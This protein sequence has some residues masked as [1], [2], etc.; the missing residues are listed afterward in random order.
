[1]KKKY[2]VELSEQEREYLHKLISSGTAPA[3]KF[4]RARIL[5]KADVDKHAEAQALNDRQIARMLETPLPQSKGHANA[6][7]REVCKPRWNALS[8]IGSTGVLWRG[9]PKLT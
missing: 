3:R 8:P 1:M 4:N 5:L 7:T 6:S 9:A 2:L